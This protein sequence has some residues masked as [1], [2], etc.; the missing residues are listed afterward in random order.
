MEKDSRWRVTALSPGLA[1]F[2]GEGRAA[3][4]V[5]QS[6]GSTVRGDAVDGKKNK[7]KKQQA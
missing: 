7:K 4:S 1:G 3:R 6:S 5:S 2:E